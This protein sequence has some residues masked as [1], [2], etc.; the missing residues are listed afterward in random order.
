[1]AEEDVAEEGVACS[2]MLPAGGT[3]S[4]IAKVRSL[5]N[6]ITLFHYQVV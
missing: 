2:R 5:T 3:L 6:V 1:M 4:S